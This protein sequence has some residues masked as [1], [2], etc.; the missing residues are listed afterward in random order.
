M[1]QRALDAGVFVVLPILVLGPMQSEG[2]LVVD[3][4]C[5]TRIEPRI[6]AHDLGDAEER[7]GGLDHRDEPGRPWCHDDGRPVKSCTFS[8]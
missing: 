1:R 5:F 8:T 2:G 3:F 4:S 7:R 6:G